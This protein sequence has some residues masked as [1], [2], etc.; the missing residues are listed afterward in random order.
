ML[1]KYRF[2]FDISGLI[3]FLIVMLPNFIWFAVP[4]PNDILRNESV[5]TIVDIIGSICQVLFVGLICVIINKERNKLRFSPLIILAVICIILYFA[6][7]ILYYNGITNPLVIIAM[8]LPPCL[9]FIFFA[10][11]RKNII[12]VVPTVC[13]TICHLIYGL[14]NFIL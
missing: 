2:G 1:K 10:L 5:T 7:W 8:T 13:F 4:A 11:D 14:V 6:G 12:A 3:I 9:A